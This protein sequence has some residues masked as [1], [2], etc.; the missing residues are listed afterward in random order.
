MTIESAPLTARERD[1]CRELVYSSDEVKIIAYRLGISEITACIHRTSIYSK[2]RV[3][4]RI[5]LVHLFLAIPAPKRERICWSKFVD[6]WL[7]RPHF[8]REGERAWKNRNRI[9]IRVRDRVR[10]RPKLMNLTAEQRQ[11]R[12]R[13]GARARWDK[14]PQFAILLLL[15]GMPR[16]HAAWVTI[17][18][19][20]VTLKSGQSQQFMASVSG[21]KSSVSWLMVPATGMGTLTQTGFYTV[22]ATAVNGATMYVEA[23][24]L[25]AN[26]GSAAAYAKVTFS[27]PVVRG[28]ILS[29]TSVSLKAGQSQQFTATVNVSGAAALDFSV[30]T[31]GPLPAPQTIP[32]F[33]PGPK[34]QKLFARAVT[35]PIVDQGAVP[36]WL[37]VSAAPE[38]VAVRI[39]HTDLEPGIY[40]GEVVVMGRGV[41]TRRYRVW[42]HVEN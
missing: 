8:K 29:P 37:E 19:A 4:S 28:V 2:L 36:Y 27:V 13:K 3:G 26:G 1:V 17:S 9:S 20:S 16:L 39:V 18:P 11:E 32:L 6:T 21:G 12:S 24:I 30:R 31:K 7:W 14:A 15:L 10:R 25:L 40:D 42:L 22:P 35:G 33:N 41:L 38:G 5:E 34:V 23:R